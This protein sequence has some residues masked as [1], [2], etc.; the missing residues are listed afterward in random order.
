M[1]MKAVLLAGGLGTRMRE[2]TELRPKPMVEIGGRPVLWH[3]MKW[4]SHSGIIDFVILTGYRS[5]YIKQYFANYR[6]N[7]F[8]FTVQ[9]GDPNSLR[10][11]GSH[12]ESDWNVTIVDT[13]Y[14]TPT[15]GRIKAVEELLSDGPFLC[16]YGDGIATVDI[17][18]LLEFHAQSGHLA[19]VTV[20]RPP[21]RFGEI[22]FD[23]DGA[24]TAFREKPL[25]RSWINIGYF[26]FGPEIFTFLKDDSTLEL[27]P[28]NALVQRRALGAFRHEGFW[29]P[30]DTQREYEAL[31]T[32]WESGEAPWRIW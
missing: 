18:S 22:E 6:I 24:V 23:G 21:S 16:T 15:G 11:Q 5:D 3:I 25:P 10:F 14:L 7:N 28:L 31:N 8:D 27:E 30:M 2:Q 29:Q 20:A 17:K 1:S 4:L 13:G 32:M 9:L 19:T 26:I 12:E